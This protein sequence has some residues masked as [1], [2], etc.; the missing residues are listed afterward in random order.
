L[1]GSDS[2]VELRDVRINGNALDDKRAYSCVASDYLMGEAERYLG[3]VPTDIIYLP[4]TLFGTVEKRIR[5]D[6][7]ITPKV[8]PALHRAQ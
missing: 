2:T 1:L 8:I 7:D 6:H 4:L 5:E 3:I